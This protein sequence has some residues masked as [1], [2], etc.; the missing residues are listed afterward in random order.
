MDLPEVSLVQ[1]RPRLLA[2]LKPPVERGGEKYTIW[3]ST[4]KREVA[5]IDDQSVR[6]FFF[7]CRRMLELYNKALAI[8]ED[9]RTLDALSYLEKEIEALYSSSVVMDVTDHKLKELFEKL[10]PVLLDA[11]RSPDCVNPKLTSLCVMIMK[12]FETQQDSRCMVFV[13]TRDLAMALKRWMEDDQH[14]SYLKPGM[15][16]GQNASADKGGMTR[17]EQVDA[18]ELFRKGN[19][20][21]IVAT[22][23]AEEGMDFSKCNLVIR[24]EYVTNEIALVQARGRARAEDSKFV[25][26]TSNQQGAAEKE[27]LN[28]IREMMMNEALV[29]LQATIAENPRRFRSEIL[30]LQKEAKSARDHEAI[31]RKGRYLSDDEFEIRCQKCNQLA[32]FSTDIRTIKETN[33]IVNDPDFGTKVN[34]KPHPK[35]GNMGL[36]MKK[37]S[38]IFCK[39]CGLDWGIGVIYKN[40]DFPVIKIESFVAIDTMGRRDSPRKWKNAPFEVPE[41]SHDEMTNYKPFIA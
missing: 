27:E 24:Y 41:I 11:A 5:N 30:Q 1:D 15:F 2:S 19:H 23:V 12:A 22:S 39:K 34:V 28:L 25:L 40:A 35:P 32:C 14:L 8:N 33:H 3:V 16:T 4:L 20:K 10:K 17:N 21:I 18:A 13:K 26:F 9:C 7:S 37:H 36:D 6:R 38:K 29:R 31:N